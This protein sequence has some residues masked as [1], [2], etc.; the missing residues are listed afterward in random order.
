MRRVWIE[1]CI[2]CSAVEKLVVTLRAEGVDRNLQLTI[3]PIVAQVTLRTESVDRNSG[4]L[5]KLRTLLADPRA[6]GRTGQ[7]E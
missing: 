5:K 1:I 3:M 4:V 7:G 6:E 2:C